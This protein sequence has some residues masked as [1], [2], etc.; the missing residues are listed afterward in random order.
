MNHNDALNLA[1]RIRRTWPKTHLDIDMWT[2]FVEELEHG[3]AE[4]ARKSLRDSE[5][6]APSFAKFRSTYRAQFGTA[7][8][9]K[10][11]CSLCSGDGWETVLVG[12]TEFDTALRPCRCPN[13][14][15]V[16]DVH[17]RIVNANDA[18]LERVGGTPP[19]DSVKRPEWITGRPE[20]ETLL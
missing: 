1:E 4:S 5:E 6:T 9:E 17:R 12:P 10:I 2:E 14:R 11:G 20:Q 15:R 3:P 16:E 18:E 8:E 7:R 19:E 13:G